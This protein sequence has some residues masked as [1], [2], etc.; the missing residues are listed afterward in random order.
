MNPVASTMTVHA[1]SV[2]ENEQQSSSQIDDNLKQSNDAEANIIPENLEKYSE[3]NTGETIEQDST[4]LDESLDDSNESTTDSEAEISETDDSVVEETEKEFEART[5]RATG[6]VLDLGI[7]TFRTL[8]IETPVVDANKTPLYDNV[9]YFDVANRDDWNNALSV[10]VTNTSETTNNNSKAEITYLNITGD[11]SLSDAT[12][13]S[14]SGDSEDLHTNKA[15]KKLIVNGNGHSIDFR[16]MNYDLNNQSWD[17][18]LQNLKMWNANDWGVFDTYNSSSLGHTIT[19]HNVEQY[20]A[21]AQEGAYGRVILSG[22]TQFA[23]THTGDY[24]SPIGDQIVKIDTRFSGGSSNIEVAEVYVKAGSDISLDNGRFGSNMSIFPKGNFYIEDSITEKPTKVLLSN[25]RTPGDG[26]GWSVADYSPAAISIVNDL[27][28]VDDQWPEDQR[29]ESLIGRTN[30]VYAG[31]NATIEVHN[32][33][34]REKHASA[35]QI[36]N[37]NG[38]VE[39]AENSKFIT[40]I[41]KDTGT[42]DTFASVPVSLTGTGS[43]V[44]R[45][46]SVFDL[47]MGKL[48]E[49][50]TTGTAVKIGGKGSIEIGEDAKF[51]V[52]SNSTVSNG[53]V[54][55]ETA[56]S[57]VTVA[58]GATLDLAFARPNRED[59]LLSLNGILSVP[60]S[61]DYTHA[62]KQWKKDNFNNNKPDNLFQPLNKTK[63]T[64]NRTTI[65]T[66]GRVTT[67]ANGFVDNGVVQDFTANY[68]SFNRRLVIEPLNYE[69]NLDEITNETKDTYTVTGT[70]L[71]PGGKVLLSGGP[72]DELDAAARTVTVQENGTFTWTGTL[73]R[74]FYAGEEI[75]GVYQGDVSAIGKTTVIDVTKPTGIGKEYH[76]LEG[77]TIPDAKAFIESVLDTNAENTNKDDFTYAF[78]TTDFTYPGVGVI[79]NSQDKQEYPGTVKITDKAGNVSDPVVDVKLVV[80]KADSINKILANDYTARW[81]EVSGFTV[82]SAEYKDYIIEKTEAKA[83]TI[84]NGDLISLPIEID[85]LP[86]I[87]NHISS[88]LVNY[89]V[90]KTA[91][92]GLADNLSKEVTWKV[93]SNLVDPTD[94][95]KPAA[96]PADPGKTPENTGTGSSKDLRLDYVP[97]TFDFGTVNFSWSEGNHKARG[98]ADE[99]Q[100]IQVADERKTE[101][102]WTLKVRATDFKASNDDT[103]SGAALSLPN[104]KVYNKKTAS[105]SNPT[106]LTGRSLTLNNA[107]QTIVTGTGDNAKNETTYVWEKNAVNLKVPGGQ[108]SVGETYKSTITWTLESG[109]SN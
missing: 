72:L 48:A 3:T 45:K 40:K 90:A 68:N 106:G 10:N 18:V 32:G 92:N 2:D 29:P 26:T 89:S 66:N 33:P 87:G 39:L 63:V 49:V 94:P 74:P 91:E 28:G 8:P 107:D 34:A 43:I 16:E 67:L 37:A 30:S 109:V 25:Q 71:P 24:E 64:Y 97:S 44:L 51:K 108:G 55:L 23:S 27:A 31:K 101:N 62:I 13:V 36:E 5:A 58:K 19:F 17:I 80:H 20:G 60:E 50:D 11:F 88:Y 84:K 75:T 96:D 65:P 1:V 6:D 46:G 57:K 76:I 98:T 69:V 93:I 61:G 7:P 47:T 54:K 99:S 38:L 42:G 70:A 15:N 73:T 4:H 95:S 14:A 53:L 78:D 22:N 81:S 105:V 41:E 56:D 21:Q 86:A 85:N 52:L 79:T 102:D 83:Y 59:H 103:L 82:G 9:I 100:W 104:G 77:E 12:S 35:L